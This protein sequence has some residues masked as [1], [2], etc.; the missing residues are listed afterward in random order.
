MKKLTLLTLAI[1]FHL[2]A[3]LASDPLFGTCPS[4]SCG[5]VEITYP[6]RI[7]G[8]QNKYCGYPGFEVSCENGN[9]PLVN[10][11]GNP[12]VIEQIWHAN[13]SFQVRNSVFRKVTGSNC[14][15]S[16]RNL[17]LEDA[18][19]QFARNYTQ[20]ALFLNCPQKNLQEYKHDLL[21]CGTLALYK[22][23]PKTRVLAGICGEV[24]YVPF[25]GDRGSNLTEVLSRGIVLN[26]TANNCT[27]CVDS[28]G[29]CGF[30]L[31]TKEPK[32]FC[33]DRA[34]AYH[35]LPSK[36][37]SLSLSLSRSVCGIPWMYKVI[38]YLGI[39]MVKTKLHAGVF[40]R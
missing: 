37:L 22:N 19:F 31:Q 32:C 25:Q 4:K 38:W 39:G 35:C 33:S 15:G 14:W 9:I 18:V 24:V 20:I 28:G 30:D 11:S 13:Q 27:A 10:I 26:W 36:P 12:Y 23:D 16:I 8:Q 5:Q 6:F 1:F 2:D 3:S 7:I 21:K 40:F 34:H 29:Q 17:T